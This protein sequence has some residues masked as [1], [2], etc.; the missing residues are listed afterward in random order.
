LFVGVVGAANQRAGLDVTDPQAE[1]FL[2]ESGK[3]LG[4]IK[5][6]HRQLLTG[7]AQILANR[8]DIDP[9]NT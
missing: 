4:G 8:D 5:A 7:G 9:H 3:L 1:T 6:R 2:L